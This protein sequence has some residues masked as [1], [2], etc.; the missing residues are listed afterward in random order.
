[1]VSN[2]GGKARIEAERRVVGFLVD[3]LNTFLDATETLLH[4]LILPGLNFIL[5]FN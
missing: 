3:N 4:N 2:I 1:M 5:V